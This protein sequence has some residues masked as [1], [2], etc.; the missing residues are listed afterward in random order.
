MGLECSPVSIEE[1][2]TVYEAAN[3]IIDSGNVS[4]VHVL[5]GMT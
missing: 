4:V 5:T 1:V 2:A 3:A